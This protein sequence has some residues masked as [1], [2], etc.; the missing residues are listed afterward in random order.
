M[1]RTLIGCRVRFDRFWDLHALRNGH[2]ELPATSFTRDTSAGPGLVGGPTAGR[3]G[4]Y[5]GQLDKEGAMVSRC[6]REPINVGRGALANVAC[7]LAT[8]S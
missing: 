1:V 2:D 3:A 5:R 4:A 6:E 7:P 8:W